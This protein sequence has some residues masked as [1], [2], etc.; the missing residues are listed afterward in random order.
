MKNFYRGNP[1]S[2]RINRLVDC[3]RS[4]ISLLSHSRTRAER[5]HKSSSKF[6]SSAT[7]ELE[8]FYVFGVTK[9]AR[10]KRRTLR[11]SRREHN[12][13]YSLAA[14]CSEERRTT[15]RGLIASSFL[16]LSPSKRDSTLLRAFLFSYFFRRVCLNSLLIKKITRA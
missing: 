3:E 5:A 9:R 13:T 10:E 8:I 16:I 14:R 4:L 1:V 15:C 11:K 6:F 12:F 7:S 2:C